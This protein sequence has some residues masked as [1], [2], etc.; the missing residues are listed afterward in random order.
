MKTK[1]DKKTTTTIQ[2]KTITMQFRIQTEVG[3]QLQNRLACFV[4][5]IICKT[6]DRAA[7]GRVVVVARIKCS[8]VGMNTPM[9]LG[10]LTLR[11]RRRFFSL[12][13]FFPQCIYVH[14][15]V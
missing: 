9:Q 11:L 14:G 3:Q 12:H 7:G 10:Y 8:K 1:T 6:S 4:V 2:Q 13:Y 15:G 5:Y